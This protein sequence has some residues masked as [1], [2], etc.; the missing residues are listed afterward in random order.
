MSSPPQDIFKVLIL[1]DDD[2]HIAQ[3]FEPFFLFML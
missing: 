2:T 1:N 3:M